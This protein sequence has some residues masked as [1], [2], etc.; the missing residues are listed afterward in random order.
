MASLFRYRAFITNKPV[1]VQNETICSTLIA[2]SSIEFQVRTC[3]LLTLNNIHKAMPRK[4]SK[5]IGILSENSETVNLVITAG[6]F[7]TCSGNTTN[8]CFTLGCAYK[9][10]VAISTFFP[11]NSNLRIR[12]LMNRNPTI[13]LTNIISYVLNNLKRSYPEISLRYRDSPDKS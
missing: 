10:N 6:L 7:S 2:R 13:R 11:L 9:S 1:I 12:V 4:R 5:S 3:I 8:P